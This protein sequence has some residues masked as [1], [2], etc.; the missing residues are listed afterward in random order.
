MD[1]DDCKRLEAKVLV[2]V[3]GDPFRSIDRGR[4][5]I[6]RSVEVLRPPARS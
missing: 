1:L 4:E 5:K 2:E 3:V 6:T